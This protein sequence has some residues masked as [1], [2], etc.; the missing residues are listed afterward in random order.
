MC[1]FIIFI[2]S[3]D[4]IKKFGNVI[5]KDFQNLNLVGIVSNRKELEH[6]LKIYS[7]DLIVLSNSKYQSNSLQKLIEDIENKIVLC[8]SKVLPRNKKH[9]LFLSLTESYASISKKLQKFN[10][11]IFDKNIRKRVHSILEDF[12]FDSKIIGTIYLLEAIVYSYL[13]LD[14]YHL[15]NLERKIYPFVSQKYHT[16]VKNVKWSIIRAI[17]IAKSHL[18]SEDL[19][20]NHIDF[21]EKLTSKTLIS[22]IVNRL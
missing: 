12:K 1:N 3:L 7:I 4:L 21:P 11:R 17:N 10:S 22:E 18:T 9:T 8:N 2:E 5:F 13:T 14:K 19:K 20:R 15:E 6:L 16:N